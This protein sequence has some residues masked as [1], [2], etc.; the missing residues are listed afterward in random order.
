MLIEAVLSEM[1]ANWS[2]GGVE[3]VSP[4]SAASH[5]LPPG[6]LM[7]SPY[8]VFW[9]SASALVRPSYFGSSV[10]IIGNCKAI[11]MALLACTGPAAGPR[12]KEI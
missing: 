12:F 4:S 8:E 6:P 2:R 11:V 5:L 10:S 3:P 7:P 1:L 9:L